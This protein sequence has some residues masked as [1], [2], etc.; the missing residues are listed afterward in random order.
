MTILRRQF[1]KT[2]L[3]SSAVGSVAGCLG[4]SID[5]LYIRNESGTQQTISIR[6]VR[7]SNDNELLD[8]T[9]TLVDGETKQYTEV[10]GEYT[11]R[12][13]INVQNG[14]SN[15]T[16][17]ADSG[18]DSYLLEISIDDSTINFQESAV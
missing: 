17:W 9:T 5:D 16:E 8:E 13:S 7:L 4:N 18:S 6:V 15:E 3:A 12:V 2:A 14:P 10:A 11:C 1:L